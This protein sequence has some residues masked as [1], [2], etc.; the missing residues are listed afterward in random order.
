[1]ATTD[2]AAACVVARALEV[3]GDRWTALVIRDAFYGIRR[4][5]DFI[6]DLGIARNVLADRLAKLVDAGILAK[7]AYQERPTRYEYRLTDKGRDLLPVFLTLWRWGD[8]W[9]ADGEPPVEVQHRTCG[10]A[11]EAEVVCRECR[12]P[13]RLRELRVD[14][15]PVRLPSRA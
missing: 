13:L 5:D 3:I 2:P 10:H 6:A 14:P 1:M 9:Y 7:V 11:T 8:R 15:I 12:E 4:F